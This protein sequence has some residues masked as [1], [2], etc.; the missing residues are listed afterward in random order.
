M[1]SKKNNGSEKPRGRMGI[2]TQTYRMDLRLWG[3]GRVSWDEVREWH[4]LKDS[5]IS[6][7]PHEM[8]GVLPIFLLV[9]FTKTIKCVETYVTVRRA[10]KSFVQL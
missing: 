9:R 7:E 2:K 10:F 8:K 5:Y 6:W 3:G 4:G 1:E